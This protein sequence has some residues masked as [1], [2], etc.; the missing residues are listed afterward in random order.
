MTEA[1]RLVFLQADLARARFMGGVRGILNTVEQYQLDK[2]DALMLIKELHD[3]EQPFID[4]A[5]AA[6]KEL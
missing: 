5:K 3:H 1:Q 4:A 2:A 6:L